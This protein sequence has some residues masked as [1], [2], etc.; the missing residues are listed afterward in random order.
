MYRNTAEKYRASGTVA[1]RATDNKVIVGLNGGDWKTVLGFF[2]AS[3]QQSEETVATYVRALT[4]FFK[5]VDATGRDFT[6]LVD[7][8]ILAYVAYLKQDSTARQPRTVSLYV[9]AIRRYYSWLNSKTGYPNIAIGVKGSKQFMNS[10]KKFVKQPLSNEQA[11][12]LLEYFREYHPVRSGRHIAFARTKEIALRNYAMVNLMLRCGLRTVEVCRL[13]IMNIGFE[14]GYRVLYVWGKGH[15]R[16][17]IG[18]QPDDYVRLTDKAYG[19]VKEYLATR[20][21]VNGNAPLFVTAGYDDEIGRLS[22]RTVQDVCKRGLRAIGLD[23]AAYSPHS[24]RHTT[25]EML[26]GKNVPL[27]DIQNAMRHQDP[28]TTEIYIA[29]AIEEKKLSSPAVA[30]L[31][32]CF[33][34]D[35]T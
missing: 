5:W 14:R 29:Q 15:D 24:L 18:S 16:P 6:R 31:D 10:R 30:A 9:C 28:A 26:A 13:N 23:D 20:G 19:P 33:E 27:L 17:G 21:Q 2:A 35:N 32:D 7:E 1:V 3:M 8:D 4:V 12:R 25:G 11:A 22:T 34:I